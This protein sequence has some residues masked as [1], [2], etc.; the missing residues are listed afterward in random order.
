MTNYVRLVFM[1]VQGEVEGETNQV[2]C[3]N[4]L[5]KI[6]N[7]QKKSYTFMIA[8]HLR[9]LIIVST[10]TLLLRLIK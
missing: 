3:T 9:L 6:I 7:L 1:R 10:G 8:D 2:L 4:F 5:S